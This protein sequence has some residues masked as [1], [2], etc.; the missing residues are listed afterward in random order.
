MEAAPIYLSR[1]SGIS[2]RSATYPESLGGPP[3]SLFSLAPDWVYTAPSV[4]LRA[5]GSYP[6]FSPL[7]RAMRNG[8]FSVALA[9]MVA[10]RHPCP[11]FHRESC[12]L[13]SGLSSTPPEAEQREPANRSDSSNCHFLQKGNRNPNRASI[14]TRKSTH[15]H[16]RNAQ[17]KGSG[18]RNHS[19][20]GP[21]PAGPLIRHPPTP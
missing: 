5:V 6:T 14:P 3:D 10:S 8:I 2:R 16:L 21:F 20:P 4:A 11:R 7:S 17:S 1:R 12:P 18:R 15:W 19:A 13:V 9:V